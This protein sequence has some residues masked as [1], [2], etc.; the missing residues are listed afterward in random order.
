VSAV[1]Y[2]LLI[3]AL[4]LIATATAFRDDISERADTGL[5]LA[6][7]AAIFLAL[8]SSPADR[9]NHNSWSDLHVSATSKAR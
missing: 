8:V 2:L 5:L 4:C 1:H 3:L 9:D 7:I 6:V